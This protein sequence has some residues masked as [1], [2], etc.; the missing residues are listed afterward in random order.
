[1]RNM[2]KHLK[3]NYFFYLLALPGTIV[4]FLFSYMPMSGIY[5]AFENYNYKGGLFGSEFV[6]WDNF[7][8]LFGN[9]DLLL[10]AIRNTLAINIGN[11]IFGTIVNVAT[12]IM[13]NE[14]GRERFRKMIQT[15]ILFPYFLSWII[16]GTLSSAL[17]DTR[18]G[19]LNQMI[20]FFGGEPI[21]WS[22]EP[23]YWQAILIIASVWKCFGYSSIV[24]YS[25]ISG[26]NPSIYEAARVD[27]ASRWKQVWHITL[28]M[29]KSTIAL[30]TLLSLGGILGGSLEQIMG[31]T[32]LGPYLLSTTDTIT[33]FVYRATM[34]DI[35]YGASA[36][37]S[38]FQSVVG[39]VLVLAA[40]LA[41]KKLD[42]D[43]ALF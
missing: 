7:K 27:G 31:M 23:Q 35:N 2:I 32:K 41:A 39:C 6:G 28:P 8:Y 20:T 37:A 42:P 36:A 22:M 17:L 1:M 21:R 38:I 40:N 29:L 33:T 30:M 24:Y 11:L 5:L 34:E 3:R 14:V 4:L 15:L 43:Y 19:V 25:T 9:A 18:G 26:F 10:R 16:V 13:L 12:A